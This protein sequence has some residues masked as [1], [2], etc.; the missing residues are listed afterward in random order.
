MET[1][2]GRYLKPT[3]EIDTIM[4]LDEGGY[5]VKALTAMTSGK[6][7]RMVYDRGKPLFENERIKNQA[8]LR[9]AQIE[10]DPANRI[11]VASAGVPNMQKGIIANHAYAVLQVN[12]QNQRVTL[13]NPHRS[14]KPID[15]TFDEF[16]Q[17]FRRLTVAR[18]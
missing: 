18:P 11:A 5:A 3:N 6:E 9:L 13:A 15:L 4:V 14:E 12:T 10:K 2:F 16:L 8:L 17:C 7:A 1:A